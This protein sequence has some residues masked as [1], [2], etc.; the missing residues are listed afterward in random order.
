MTAR[1]VHWIR[2]TKDNPC[3]IC[4]RPDWCGFS[5]EIKTVICMRIVSTK[6]A[7]NGGYI[8]SVTD[9]PIRYEK[10]SEPPKPE[11]DA[12]AMMFEF[13]SKTPIYMLD[14]L[15]KAIGVSTA[16]LCLMG[17]AWAKPHNAFAFPMVNGSGQKIGIRLRAASGAKWAV[18]GSRQGIFIPQTLADDVAFIV[19]GPT[20]CAAALTMGVFPI[21]R[22]SCRGSVSYTQIAINRL[23]INRAVLIADNDPS[24]FDEKVKRWIPSPGIEG[25]KALAN[26]LQVPCCNLVL[27]AK[28][29]REFLNL[30][31]TK[32][33]IGSLV[34][35]LVWHNP[36]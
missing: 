7:K 25:A 8:H 2:V 6:P 29:M 35:S 12:E 22:P 31:G 9:A 26:E 24:K 15:S 27:P 17:C 33:F 14:Q 3:P 21:G 23:N 32:E 18:T 5:P 30:G 1:S 13:R 20:D 19:E 10:N 16:A 4:K 36:D 11:I 28:D 34:G